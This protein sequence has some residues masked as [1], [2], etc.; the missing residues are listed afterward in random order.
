MT[1]GQQ[2]QRDYRNGKERIKDPETGE[3]YPAPRRK[4]TETT[5]E[6]YTRHTRNMMA[7]FTVLAV[8]GIV[9]GV[10]GIDALHHIKNGVGGY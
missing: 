8:A 5:Q 4:D 3:L 6:R 7:F 2:P 1:T 9:V 10:F